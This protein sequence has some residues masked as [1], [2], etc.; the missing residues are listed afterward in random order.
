RQ[1]ANAY[2]EAIINPRVRLL[3]EPS[4]AE[5]HVYHL[6]VVICQ[7]RDRLAAYLKSAGI[8]TYVHYPVPVHFQSPCKGLRRDPRGLPMAELHAANCLS[9][10]CHPQLSD[11]DVS[12]VIDA[13]NAFN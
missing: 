3:A 2:R 13:I 9:I 1:I 11:A 12:T 10:P 8:E 4:Q 7:E 6:F 5:S